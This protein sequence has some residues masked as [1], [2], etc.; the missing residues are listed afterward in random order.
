MSGLKVPDIEGDRLRDA[1]VEAAMLYRDDDSFGRDVDKAVDA[2]KSHHRTKSAPEVSPNNANPPSGYELIEP[3]G[4]QCKCPGSWTDGK[5][6][7][8]CCK[9][10]IYRAQCEPPRFF[11]E[12]GLIHDRVTGKHVTTDADSPFY[13]GI[14]ACCD[15][16]NQLAVASPALPDKHVEPTDEVIRLQTQLHDGAGHIR[17]MVKSLS[18]RVI[19]TYCGLP[20]QT[21]GENALQ[22]ADEVDPA[23]E[24]GDGAPTCN[25]DLQVVAVEPALTD[26]LLKDIRM[27]ALSSDSD[28]YLTRARERLTKPN[29]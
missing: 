13:D 14:R 9:G 24:P 16:L 4:A 2:L 21:A 1:V 29:R 27:I 19:E 15:L 22:W 25:D 26:D 23:K 12:H 17:A 28:E 10:Q 8:W 5:G 7:Y 18:R 20:F 6:A 3:V 11:I